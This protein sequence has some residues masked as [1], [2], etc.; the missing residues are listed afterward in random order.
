MSGSEWAVRGNSIQGSA[1]RTWRRSHRAP[2]L[3]TTQSCICIRK[4]QNTLSLRCGHKATEP[5][6]LEFRSPEIGTRQERCITH[7]YSASQRY[8]TNDIPR[9][10][11]GAS[12][13][14]K[15]R[16]TKSASSAKRKKATRAQVGRHPT[17]TRDVGS[18]RYDGLASFVL[19]SGRP[20]N[21]VAPPVVVRWRRRT[22]RRTVGLSGGV[23]SGGLLLRELSEIELPELPPRDG[24]P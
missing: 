13:T 21:F 10:L 3:I 20:C 1:S 7:Y 2:I 8:Y 16:R 18:H 14:S 24:T 5:A 23:F 9:L 4:T 15:E 12:P 11:F 22:R 6:R 19:I 17:L